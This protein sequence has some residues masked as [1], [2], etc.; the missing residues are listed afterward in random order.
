M[1][2]LYMVCQKYGVAFD[3]T[4]VNHLVTTCYQ[5]R[6]LEMRACHPRDVIEHMVNLCRYRRQPATITQK[7]IDEVCRTYFLDEP[8]AGTKALV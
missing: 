7:L 5:E 2:I 6:G 1:A 3:Q 4:A 8:V